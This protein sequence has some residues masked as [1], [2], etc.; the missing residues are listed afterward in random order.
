MTQTRLDGMR[1]DRIA[2]AIV[3]DA[4]T[5]EEVALGWYYYL[6]KTL[7]FPFPARWLSSSSA[8]LAE[9]EAVE[10][11]GMPP[12][13]TCDRAIYVLIAYDGDEL[14]VPL[15]NIQA[16]TGDALTQQAIADWHYWIDQGYV[17]GD[18]DYDDDDYA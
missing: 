15:M 11:I 1:E 18:D 16:P 6:E 5:P 2:R 13:E 8:T 7:Q 17:F 14:T 9:G 10:V 4:Y 3:V 12:E